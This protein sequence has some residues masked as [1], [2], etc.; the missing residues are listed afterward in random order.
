M[1]KLSIYHI[2][3]ILLSCVVLATTEK[4][5]NEQQ[6]EDAASQKFGVV[7]L[8]DM[9]YI[10]EIWEPEIAEVAQVSK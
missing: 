6:G 8:I 5:E 2:L 3:F 9:K 1:T 7:D 4:V 10:Y